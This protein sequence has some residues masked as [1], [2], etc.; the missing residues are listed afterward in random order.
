MTSIVLCVA[1]LL[2]AATATA[3][4]VRSVRAFYVQMPAE[5]G[6][7]IVIVEPIG[8]DVRVR[9]VR[10]AFA[11]PLCPATLVQAVERILP[12]TT[13]QAVAGVR[14]CAI[15]NQRAALALKR[16]PDHHTYIDFGFSTDT[17]VAACQDGERVFVFQQPPMVNEKTLRRQAPDVAALWTLGRKARALATTRPDRDPLFGATD[18][19]R[20][21]HEALGTS[22][23]P[24]LVSGKYDTLFRIL[25][26][27]GRDLKAYTGSPAQR[28]PLPVEL[29]ERDSLH[30]ST[31]VAPVMPPIALSARVF[32]DVRLRITVNPGTGAVTDV[33]PLTGSP[34]HV[35]AAI[36]AAR[37]W[38]FAPADAPR[39]PIDVTLRFQLR[40]APEQ[41]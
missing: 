28:E 5:D 9:V 40:C 32:G 23:V 7:D 15:S 26:Y 19:E 35:G 2:C 33:Q 10:I 4:P 16:A 39:D 37:Q 12:H 36:D 25:S 6:N 1:V 29:V 41:Q 3:Q 18:E 17:V 21:A 14:I 38:R 30:L 27:V 34:L 8:E 20:V 13:A 22:L 24:E 31:Y 11:H